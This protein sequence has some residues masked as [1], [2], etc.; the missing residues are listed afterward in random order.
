MEIAT[1]VM[2]GAGVSLLVWLHFRLNTQTSTHKGDGNKNGV[3][4]DTST[5][6][7]GR[8]EAVVVSGFILG[9]LYVPT[10]VLNELQM[11][12]DGK[13]TY[14][15]DRAR[16]GLEVL[17]RLRALPRITVHIEAKA[18]NSNTTDSTDLQVLA[19]AQKLHVPLCTTDYALLKRAETLGVLTMNINELA[20]GLREQLYVGDMIEVTLKERGEYKEQGV[21]HTADGTLV[22]VE[23]GG[24]LIGQS[25]SARIKKITQTKTGRMVFARLAR[26]KTS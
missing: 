15:R 3:V 6:I 19:C 2:S 13:D 9:A 26:N 10:A 24:L 16:N 18:L 17:A 5:L 14:K 4:L 7:D 21:G 1:L 25:V 12:A 20:E 22:I 23:D 8:I 11:L